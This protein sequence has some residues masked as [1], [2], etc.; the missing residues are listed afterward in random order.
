MSLNLHCFLLYSTGTL[1]SFTKFLA[2][3]NL[4]YFLIRKESGSFPYSLDVGIST[5]GFTLITAPY[6]IGDFVE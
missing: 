2:K 6:S 4:F 1:N 5:M 3:I